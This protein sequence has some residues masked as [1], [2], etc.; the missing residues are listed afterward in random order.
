MYYVKIM[1]TTTTKKITP[2]TSAKKADSKTETT[3]ETPTAQKSGFAIIETGGKQYKVF[4]GDTIKIEKLAGTHKEG[5]KIIFDKVLLVS[6]GKDVK[7]GTP[8]VSGAKVEA[9][10][11]GEG[12]NKKITVIKFK[13]KSR[14]RRKAGHKQPHTKVK[15]Q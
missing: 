3:K 10:F 2:K 7:I 9:V 13:S 5:A 12:R 8:Y 14:Y 1:E 15:I 11:E 6:D 4:S